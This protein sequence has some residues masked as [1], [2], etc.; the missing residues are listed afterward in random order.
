MKI[1]FAFI[2]VVIVIGAFSFSAPSVDA[3]YDRA[4]AARLHGRIL[5][6]VEEHGEAW[7]IRSTDSKRYY[8]KDGP[9]A[10]AIM[11]FFSLG[12]TDTDLARIPQ[13]ADTAEM[14][15]SVSACA[16]NALA[17]R[18]RGEILLRVEQ[19]GEAWYVDPE[20]CRAIYMKDGEVAY[21]VMRFLGLGITN[22]NLTKI[23]DGG[24]VGGTGTETAET[25][26]AKSTGTVALQKG[27]Q[28]IGFLTT[29]SRELQNVS[30]AGAAWTRPHPGPFDWGMIEKSQGTFDFSQTDAYVLAAQ[31]RGIRILA[32]VWPFAQWD[33]QDRPECQVSTTDQ[34]YPKTTPD[35][36]TH[37]ITPWRCKPSNMA[38]Y[39]TFLGKLVDRYDGNGVNDMPGLAVPVTHWEVANEPDLRASPDLTFFIGSEADYLGLLQ[40][41]YETIKNTCAEC[42]VVHGGAAGSHQEAIAFWDTVFRLGGGQYFD[43]ANVHYIASGEHGT[44]NT[45]P[46][47]SLL[48][49]YGINKP[50]WVT[51][52]QFPN[53]ASDVVGQTRGAFAA[54]AERI[55]Y[56]SF[57]VG[58]L[59][60]PQLGVVDDRYTQA[61][62]LCPQ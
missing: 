39:R 49:T 55:F 3:A 62:D 43:V 47:K 7:Y 4:W 56:V 35:G 34:F 54:G 11:R 25:D 22:T 6:Q 51:E 38:A 23:E 61:S 46:F 18:L 29:F 17:N 13:V 20:K 48:D 28:C 53:T 50:L 2:L 1:R 5:L 57:N 37:G 44:M 59:S 42:Q 58:G 45:A 8:M 60:P 15:A 16:S 19:H 41:S 27:P 33:Q 14:K 32:T 36:G 52:A 21:E 40:A 10:Y 24:S 12:I 30:V 26:R 9:A 31:D